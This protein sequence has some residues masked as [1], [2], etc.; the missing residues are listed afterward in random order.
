MSTIKINIKTIRNNKIQTKLEE[1][2]T[3][4]RAIT[5]RENA[6]NFLLEEVSRHIMELES[7]FKRSTRDVTDE[8]I[9]RWNVDL[10][11]HL[12][13][14]GYVAEKY[15]KLLQFQTSNGEILLAVEGIGK[16]YENLVSSKQTFVPLLKSEVSRRELDKKDLIKEAN[17]NIKLAKFSGYDS[18]LDI[19]SFQLE[20]EK[21]HLRTVT[22]RVLP[23]LLINNYLSEPAVLLVKSL[24]DIDEIW[25]VLKA[26]YGDTKMLLAKKLGC[27][28]LAKIREPEK[29]ITKITQIINV[30]KD[31]LKLATKHR[32]EKHLF[33]GGALERIYKLLG[34]HRMIRIVKS[35]S[36]IRTRGLESYSVFLM[37]VIC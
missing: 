13:V 37:P 36:N 28:S 30:M 34:E 15:Q 8:E 17:L 10:T 1:R 29:L 5:Q 3:Q 27:D 31:L 9:S 24:D 14:F 33:Y 25:R 16:R 22:R 2:R 19:Y 12:K 21:L 6:T 23:D 32:I 20:F 18:Q 11:D 35:C 26:T 7:I 4:Q